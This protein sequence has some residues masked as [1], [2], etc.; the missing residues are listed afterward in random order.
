MTYSMFKDHE[1]AIEAIAQKL[2]D[3]EPSPENILQASI[4]CMREEAYYC[5]PTARPETVEALLLMFENFYQDIVDEIDTTEN[6]GEANTNR[7]I[8]EANRFG[9]CMRKTL[10]M[11]NS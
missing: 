9:L 2:G 11:M 7:V 3:H 10:K 1:A 4:S 8:R 5:Y 6:W